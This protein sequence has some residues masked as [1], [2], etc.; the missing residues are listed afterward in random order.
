MLP[1]DASPS[2]PGICDAEYVA[3][4]AA[5]SSPPGVVS[6]CGI[7]TCGTNPFVVAGKFLFGDASVLCGK[8]SSS[9]SSCRSGAFIGV[10][11]LVQGFWGGG[12]NSRSSSV[13]LRG[14]FFVLLCFGLRGICGVSRSKKCVGI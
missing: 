6:V 10:A 7:W 5:V 11:K 1:W 13:A 14:R 12:A 4:G 2:K 9:F 8:H 3:V